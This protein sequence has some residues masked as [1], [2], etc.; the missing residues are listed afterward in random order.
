M[1]VSHPSTSRSPAPP[2]VGKAP[3]T[4]MS[5]PERTGT[6]GASAVT[7]TYSA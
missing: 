4:T 3:A 6:G 5:R 2:A 1:T 7:A